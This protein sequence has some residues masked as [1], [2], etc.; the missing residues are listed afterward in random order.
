MRHENNEI[1]QKHDDKC[2]KH[3]DKCGKREKN[4]SAT[5]YTEE[6]RQRMVYGERNT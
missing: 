2:G 4:H 6:T 1:V 5:K 3:D